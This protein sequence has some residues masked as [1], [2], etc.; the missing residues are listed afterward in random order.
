[1]PYNH[2]G[3]TGNSPSDPAP[4]GTVENVR[5]DD[6]ETSMHTDCTPETVENTIYGHRHFRIY[7]GLENLVFRA[8]NETHDVVIGCAEDDPSSVVDATTTV[9]IGPSSNS[10]FKVINGQAQDILTV[11]SSETR[12][13]ERGTVYI[14]GVYGTSVYFGV[15]PYVLEY[16]GSNGNLQSRSIASLAHLIYGMDNFTN[17]V[18]SAKTIGGQV[19]VSIGLT[20]QKMH[21]SIEIWIELPFRINMKADETTIDSQDYIGAIL[22]DVDGTATLFG[23]RLANNSGNAYSTLWFV[24]LAAIDDDAVVRVGARFVVSVTDPAFVNAITL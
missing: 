6:I 17:E 12:I 16:N 23:L 18:V 22:G 1:M 3:Y 15:S 7:D 24:P 10:H 20:G 2:L 19:E 8:D 11:N 14:G 13:G 21:A 4:W 5:L 9:C